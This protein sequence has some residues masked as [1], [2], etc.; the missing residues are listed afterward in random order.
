MTAPKRLSICSCH[1][2]G[3]VRFAETGG[4]LWLSELLAREPHLIGCDGVLGLLWTISTAFWSGRE[5]T[6]SS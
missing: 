6:C 1:D 4:L 3:E 2:F 5:K